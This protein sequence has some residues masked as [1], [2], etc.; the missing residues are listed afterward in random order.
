MP[1]G[2]YRVRWRPRT[3]GTLLVDI[4]L[5]PNLADGRYTSTLNLG[6]AEDPALISIALDAEVGPSVSLVP[7]KIWLTRD[8]ASGKYRPAQVIALS[9][10]PQV[11]VPSLEPVD[12]PSGVR[13]RD[14]TSQPSGMRRLLIQADA[15]LEVP[16]EGLQLLLRASETGQT[17]QV[18]VFIAGDTPGNHSVTAEHDCE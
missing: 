17:L 2:A 18:T 12:W 1:G 13:L 4:S 14:V 8:A 11:P 16:E 7:A 15:T 6:P 9:Y 3:D 5:R 10:K